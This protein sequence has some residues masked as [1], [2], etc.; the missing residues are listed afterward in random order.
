MKRNNIINKKKK[1]TSNW[2]WMLIILSYIVFHITNINNGHGKEHTPAVPIRKYQR[3]YKL[4]EFVPTPFL[5]IKGVGSFPPLPKK[6][7]SENPV[8]NSISNKKKKLRKW[9]I[10]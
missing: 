4:G 9:R 5:E 7:F 8:Y 10:F 1:I 2:S 6:T 3:G